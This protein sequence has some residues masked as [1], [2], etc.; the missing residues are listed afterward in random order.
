MKTLRKKHFKKYVKCDEILFENINNIARV[1]NPYLHVIRAHPFFLK[2]YKKLIDDDKNFKLDFFKNFFKT[3][4]FLLSHLFY[5]NTFFEQI[6]K[7]NNNDVVVVSHLV[8]K[9]NFF[10]LILKII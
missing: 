8:S 2:Q 7:L 6:L 10:N 3:I 4:F 9:K 5:K 1:A